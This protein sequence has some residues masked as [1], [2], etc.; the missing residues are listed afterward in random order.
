[1]ITQNIEL[2]DGKS[3]SITIKADGDCVTVSQQLMTN[4]VRA[5]TRHCTIT[6]SATGKSH[7]WTCA[8]DKDCL[9]D[10]RDPENPKGSCL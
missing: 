2:T 7:S 9:G 4:N 10:C 3:I 5:S 8:G 6:C 1:M